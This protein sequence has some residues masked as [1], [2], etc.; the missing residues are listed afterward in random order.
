MLLPQAPSKIRRLLSVSLLTRGHRIGKS[1][2]RPPVH[3]PGENV[4]PGQAERYRIAAEQ[5]NLKRFSAPRRLRPDRKR[6]IE[7]V[8]F[9]ILW[10]PCLVCFVDAR[11]AAE[12]GPGG[13]TTT[14]TGWH[15]ARHRE[16]QQHSEAE[17]EQHAASPAG[18]QRE[19][20]EGGRCTAGTSWRT[21][22]GVEKEEQE[23][24]ADG[25]D[26]SSAFHGAPGMVLQGRIVAVCDILGGRPVPGG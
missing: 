16:K 7:P 26:G 20:A 6:E 8:Q 14:I 10:N 1:P 9:D 4:C 17:P 22:P 21:R 15:L 2:G 11:W 23:R 5:A 12:S 18:G 3:R 19:A 24:F 25:P 13:A